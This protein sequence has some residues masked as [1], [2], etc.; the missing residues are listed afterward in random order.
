[1]AASTG[2]LY[3]GFNQDHGCFACGTD[4]GFR[5]YNCD[6]FK[7]TF[8]RGASARARAAHRRM[9]RCR[10]ERAVAPRARLRARAMG[11]DGL[12][13]TTRLRRRAQT[14]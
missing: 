11:A 6:P 10:R 8:R 2:L 4:S 14:F 9:A 3:V 5:I 12:L 13:A 7:Q 1:M